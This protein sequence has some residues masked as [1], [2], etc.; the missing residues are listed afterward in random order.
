MPKNTKPI[1]LMNERGISDIERKAA[2]EGA[3]E[4]LALGNVQRLVEIIDYGDWRTND[5]KHSS[6]KLNPFE[7]IDWYIDSAK[8]QDSS[9]YDAD[10][11]LSNFSGEKWRDKTRGGRNHYDL[12]L[13]SKDLKSSSHQNLN[14]VIGLSQKYIGAVVTNHKFKRLDDEL[15]FECMKTATMHE[16]GHALGLCYRT[17]GI[18][19]DRDS[20]NYGHCINTCVMHQGNSVPHDWIQ[21]SKDRRRNGALCIDCKKELKDYFGT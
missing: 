9:Q 16:L 3:K 20:T 13:C 17:H 21:M 1:Y 15:L 2:F 10:M 5:Y 6:G 19:R 7:S 14:F 18:D 12:L 4:L 11:I 8:I